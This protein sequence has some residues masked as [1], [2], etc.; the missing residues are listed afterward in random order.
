MQ[1]ETTMT[2]TE[3][4]IFLV[5]GFSP[6]F[7]AIR[8]RN[9][10]IIFIFTIIIVILLMG[11][12]E[13]HIVVSGQFTILDIFECIDLNSITKMDLPFQMNFQ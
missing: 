8:D 5:S 7:Y 11:E 1:I 3:N 6:V 2:K 12:N 10:E 9:M 4:Y 13:N